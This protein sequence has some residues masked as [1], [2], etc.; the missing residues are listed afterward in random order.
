[1]H[2]CA[3]AIG[4]DVRDGS[5]RSLLRRAFV[6]A[7]AI[8]CI[9]SLLGVG[10]NALRS[11]GVKLFDFASIRAQRWRTIVEKSRGTITEVDLGTAYWI[12]KSKRALFVDARS[13]REYRPGHIPG[14]IHLP[15]GRHS[16]YFGDAI[17][18]VDRRRELVLYCEA[19]D[20]NQARE[21]AL[22]FFEKGFKNIRVFQE[23][24]KRWV[25]AGH[26]R[27]VGSRVRW[28]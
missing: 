25:E 23:G 11:G 3:R 2:K 13:E 28:R 26:P 9:C 6:E 19:D 18:S 1:M 27:E 21:L 22:F 17:G 5:M 15:Y 7:F 16:A 24:W 10:V 4:L 20:C 14:A 12:Y 8:G